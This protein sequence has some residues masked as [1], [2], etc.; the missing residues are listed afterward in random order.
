MSGCAKI[1]KFCRF[2]YPIRMWAIIL[3]V[4]NLSAVTRKSSIVADENHYLNF[5]ASPSRASFAVYLS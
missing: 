5:S 4:L 2:A 3:E 1:T